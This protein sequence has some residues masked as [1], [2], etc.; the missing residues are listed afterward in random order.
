[1]EFYEEKYQ[2]TYHDARFNLARD[3]SRSSK[4]IESAK[5][6]RWSAIVKN[7]LFG[8]LTQSARVAEGI[9]VFDAKG[10]VERVRM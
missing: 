8:K 3:I 4:N 1:M 2:V 6:P 10:H 7:E 5:E 9:K